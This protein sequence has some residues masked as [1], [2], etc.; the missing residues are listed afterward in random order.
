MT[1]NLTEVSSVNL[2]K[3]TKNVDPSSNTIETQAVFSPKLTA[4][5]KN[6]ENTSLAVK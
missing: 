2:V 4:C 5:G 3:S 1:V 6:T